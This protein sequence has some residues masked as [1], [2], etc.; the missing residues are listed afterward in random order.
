MMPQT[1]AGRLVGQDGGPGCGRLRQPHHLL[2]ASAEHA[3]DSP[4]WLVQLL[5]TALALGFP[6]A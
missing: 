6:Q 1:R 3:I 5:S 4:L 2:Q